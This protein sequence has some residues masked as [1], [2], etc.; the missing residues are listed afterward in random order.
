MR[1][2]PNRG[3]LFFGYPE[4]LLSVSSLRSTSPKYWAGI[5]R[6]SRAERRIHQQ[7]F[8]CSTQPVDA[9]KYIQERMS[10]ADHILLDF[11]HKEMRVEGRRA[12]PPKLQGVSG[13]GI[14]HIS[15]KRMRGPLVAIASQ[16]RRRSRLIV[17][18]IK[19]FLAMVRELKATS[20]RGILNRS[21]H[22]SKVI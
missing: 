18:T 22:R 21:D 19:H 16:N 20:Q 11:D 6:V 9:A 2:D 1:T 5:V 4:Y 10:K 15:R 14:F 3:R 12:S 8:R 13:G 17:G 7:S